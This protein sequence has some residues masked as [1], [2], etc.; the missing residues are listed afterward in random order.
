MRTDW[1]EWRAGLGSG[2]GNTWA[3]LNSSQV[4][5]DQQVTDSKGLSTLQAQS[6]AKLPATGPVKSLS[7][8]FMLFNGAISPLNASSL[9]CSVHA[10]SGSS[11]SLRL[12]QRGAFCSTLSTR[13]FSCSGLAL[14]ATTVYSAR[15]RIIGLQRH[16][17]MLEIC[18][19]RMKTLFV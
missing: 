14:N 7:S 9:F 2:I 5:V 19:I 18:S 13:M 16:S 17:V 6:Q 15:S 4:V 1:Q 3:S 8:L 11:L 10:S 12:V